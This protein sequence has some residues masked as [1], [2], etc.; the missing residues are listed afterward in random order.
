MLK[1]KLT[2]KL[3]GIIFIFNILL[4]FISIYNIK[5]FQNYITQDIKSLTIKRIKFETKDNVNLLIQNLE[6]IQKI[7]PTDPY[8]ITKNA[9]DKLFLSYILPL[10]DKYKNDKDIKKIIFEII[11]TYKYEIPLTE[12]KKSFIIVNAK[13]NTILYHPKKEL[14]GKYF[15]IPKEQYGGFIHRK[16]KYLF[17]KHF[18]PFNW[19]IVCEISKKDIFSTEKSI[20]DI[21]KKIRWGKNH[22]FFGY[23]KINNEYIFVFHPYLT[24]KLNIKEKDI[25]GKFFKEELLKKAL[26][27]GGFVTYYFKNPATGKIEKKLTYATYYPPLNLIIATGT[28]LSD[29]NH[30]T[31]NIKKE[32]N[33]NII[34]NIIQT[35]LINLLILIISFAIFYMLIKKFLI[36]PLKNLEKAITSLKETKNIQTDLYS[37]FS[38]FVQEAKNKLKT[39]IKL[40]KGI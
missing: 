3:L 28:Y 15:Y 8:V 19:I 33:E 6:K 22:Y 17:F 35:L 29:I 37:E 24:G 10:Y 30:I 14:I 31:E 23:K 34:T 13:N 36:T 21:I 40:L 27:G 32:I 7:Y 9:T 11:K 1:T 18:R 4:S 26:N 38:K 12:R 16:N 2:G 39:V 20:Y 5:Q 25:T